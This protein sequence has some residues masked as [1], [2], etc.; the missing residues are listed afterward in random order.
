MVI[1]SV[2]NIPN[3]WI[4]DRELNL[5]FFYY[6][7]AYKK[8][9]ILDKHVQFLTGA[10]NFVSAHM[11]FL[12]VSNIRLK[13]ISNT[14]IRKYSK[15]DCPSNGDGGDGGDQCKGDGGDQCKGA[16]DGSKGDG[17]GSEN[18]NKNGIDNHGAQTIAM[19][20]RQLK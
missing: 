15:L 7:N 14:Q 4:F 3:T 19:M 11:Q 9:A 13:L 6:S 2:P 12:Q 17:G 16:G 18:A 8:C 1:V 5:Q 20:V 10:R